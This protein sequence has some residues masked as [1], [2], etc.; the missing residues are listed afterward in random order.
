[1][2][3]LFLT[4]PILQTLSAKLSWSHYI[5]ILKSDD[6]LEISFYVKSCENWSVREL[7]RQMES[8][9]FHRV[10]LSKDK[11]GVLR[12]SEKGIEVQTEVSH[13]R[14]AGK[15]GVKVCFL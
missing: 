5:E 6:A 3:K 13:G 11:E 14:G 10:A 4:F 12:L 15:R 1:M 2:L 8:M 9:L 7:K